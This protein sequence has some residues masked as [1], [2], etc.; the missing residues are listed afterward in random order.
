MNED[1]GSGCWSGGWE[2][3]TGGSITS[4]A[5]ALDELLDVALDKRL[6]EALGH[7]QHRE[8]HVAALQEVHTVAVVALPVQRLA[9][10]QLHVIAATHPHILVCQQNATATC[11]SASR[12]L[13][14]LCALH[15][16]CVC[17]RLHFPHG[18]HSTLPLGMQERA[19]RLQGVLH[20]RHAHANHRHP[21]A[22]AGA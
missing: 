8:L 20:T 5:H 13:R 19:S 12:T 7:E 14:R 1:D 16:R 9:R 6:L 18:L 3:M 10:R 17:Q 11:L 4:L 15:T 21:R 2:V 22:L